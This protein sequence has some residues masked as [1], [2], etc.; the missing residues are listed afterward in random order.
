MVSMQSQIKELYQRIER[1]KTRYNRLSE[2][3]DKVISAISKKYNIPPSELR[4]I[5]IEIRKDMLGVV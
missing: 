2:E 4:D 1:E 5:Q 3:Y